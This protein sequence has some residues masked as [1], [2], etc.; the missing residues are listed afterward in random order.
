MINRAGTWFVI[1][2]S[3]LNP[4]ACWT[5]GGRGDAQES[6]YIIIVYKSI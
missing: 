6:N 2:V 1:T 4:V 5:S 3:L